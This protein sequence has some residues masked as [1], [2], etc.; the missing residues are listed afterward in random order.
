MR[1][2]ENHD[3][4]S[5]VSEVWGWADHEK[6]VLTRK[7]WLDLCDEGGSDPLQCLF[8]VRFKPNAARVRDMYAL[9]LGSGAEIGEQHEAA[10]A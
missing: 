10:T 1:G 2:F 7:V 6:D 5:P 9:V 3:F 8:L 4:T